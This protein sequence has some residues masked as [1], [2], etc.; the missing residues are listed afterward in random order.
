M[1]LQRKVLGSILSSA[2][3]KKMKEGRGRGG[4]GGE[5]GRQD[6]KNILGDDTIKEK[7]TFPRR[8]G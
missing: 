3:R 8:R 2:S 7:A 4:R 6:K 1:W 5:G